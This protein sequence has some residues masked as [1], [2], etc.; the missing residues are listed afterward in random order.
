MPGE[1][2]LVIQSHN[3]RAAA[4]GWLARCLGSVRAWSEENGFDYAFHGDSALALAPDWYRAKAARKWP[5]VMDLARLLLL[6]EGLEVQGYERVVW[7]DADCLIFA[8]ERLSVDITGSHAFGRE[9]WVERARQGGHLKVHRS[10]HNAA[11]VFRRGDPVLPFLMHCTESIIQRIDP[12]RIAPQIVGPKLL[13]GLHAMAGFELLAAV[14]A[15]SPPVLAD[16]AA[17]GGAALERLQQ[18][19]DPPPAAAN[20]CLSL[21]GSVGH[22]TVAAAC[23]RLLDAPNWNISN[24]GKPPSFAGETA[25]V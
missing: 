7:L 18:D 23:Q 19:S 10:V 12:A 5:V 9:V 22:A 3:E 8:P 1:R 11:M 20:L 13:S 2:T 6:R 17:G 16:I 25:A 24:N 4:E 14:G 15:F 21:A